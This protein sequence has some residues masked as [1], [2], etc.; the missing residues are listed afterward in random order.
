MVVKRET[1]PEGRSQNASA[2]DALQEARKMLPG[3]PRTDA[4]K[5]AGLLRRVADNRVDLCG[6]GRP[7]SS[8]SQSKLSLP[9]LDPT[10]ATPRS[11]TLDRALSLIAGSIVVAIIMVAR[12]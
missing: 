6:R 8:W 4:R 12:Y 2:M 7:G 1:S 5:K 3:A 10:A 9:R 11:K